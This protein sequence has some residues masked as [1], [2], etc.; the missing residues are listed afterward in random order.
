[1]TAQLVTL[2]LINSAIKD[3]D[4]SVCACACLCLLVDHTMSPHPSD[5]LSEKSH[6]STTALQWSE[7]AKIKSAIDLIS[8][9][10]TKI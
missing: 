3:K 4:R 8:D 1:M 7:V 9:K 2:F 6:V 5:Q 10:V